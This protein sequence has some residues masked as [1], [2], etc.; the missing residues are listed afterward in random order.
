MRKKILIIGSDSNYAIE[1]H[2][3]KYLNENFDITLFSAQELFLKYYKHSVFNKIK[4]RLGISDIY[5]EINKMILTLSSKLKP[6]IVFVFKGMEVLP[7]TLAALKANEVLLVNYNPDNPFIFSGRGSGNVNIT[8]SLHLY[9]IHFTYDRGIAIQIEESTKKP[10]FILPFGFEISTNLFSQISK[11][12]EIVKTCFVGTP[13]KFRKEF[14][15]Y[16]AENGIQLDVYGS[17]WNKWI[18]HKNIRIFPPVYDSGLYIT[19]YRYRI[20]LNY[21]RPHNL[22][23]HNMRSFEIPG[24]GG[25]QLAPATTDHSLYFVENDEIFCYKNLRDCVQKIHTILNFTE[26][27]AQS[28]RICARKKSVESGYDYQSRSKYVT[29]VLS[30]F[31]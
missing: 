12:K 27:Q 20:Q 24:V 28:I 31:I 18:N 6:D 3:E 26:E 23:S 30:E 16:L 19:L 1:R 15:L 7:A 14:L 10:V 17:D 4:F 2:Y 21:M 9:D 8:R 25:I 11:E 22:N 13:D 5:D 29:T